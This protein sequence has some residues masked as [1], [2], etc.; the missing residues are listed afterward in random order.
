[1]AE[2][3][4]NYESK[5]F[6]DLV[7]QLMSLQN[8]MYKTYDDDK[9]LRDRLLTDVD[10]SSIQIPL[11]DRIPRTS[12]QTIEMIYNWMREKDRSAGS[13]VHLSDEPGDDEEYYESYIYYL[14]QRYMGEAWICI[15]KP[16]KTVENR[17]RGGRGG[18]GGRETLER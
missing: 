15:R 8:K 1:M 14:G 18:R 17:G 12:H 5:V 9:T 2:R 10:I 4:N 11:T 3:P 13:S 7:A 16:W 6:R